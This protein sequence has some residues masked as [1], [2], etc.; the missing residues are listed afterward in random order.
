MV[1]DAGEGDSGGKASWLHAIFFFDREIFFFSSFF[2][3]DLE[4]FGKTKSFSLF[5]FS[6]S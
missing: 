6:F 4:G 3:F 5:L 1:G 2:I